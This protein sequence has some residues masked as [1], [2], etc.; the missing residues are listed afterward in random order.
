MT[1]RL[2]GIVVPAVTP[3]RPDG[4]LDLRAFAGNL[5]RWGRTGVAGYLVLGSNGEFRS[6]S[7]DEALAVVETAAA[8]TGGRTLL[9]GAGR[10]SLRL[11]VRFIDEVAA[12]G[13]VDA[14][15]VLTPHYF[16]GAMSD[17]ALVAYYRDVA[18]RSPLP[19]LVYVAPA[20]ANGVTL[21]APAVAALAEH[22]NICGI[23]D[24]SAERLRAYLA[25]GG[26][27]GF[28]VLAGSINALLACLEHGG[29]GGV[30]SAANYLPSRCVEVV[31]LVA[32][33]RVE[34]AARRLA[35]LQQVVALTAGGHSVAGVKACMNLLGYAGGVPRLPVR[36]VPAEVTEPMRALLEQ[37]LAP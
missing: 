21:P 36:P 14:V 30:V 28:A 13:G 25:G 7:D 26:R 8:G 29:S 12:I 11:T 10:E 31:D 6:L 5:E 3:F 34:D 18:D 2:R 37:A 4:E 23:K 9:V 24:G 1:D 33:G 35:S 27:P 17:D 22:A 16:A 15:A 32:A 20:F 19:V